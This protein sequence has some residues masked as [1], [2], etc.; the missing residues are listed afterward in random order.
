MRVT[1]CRRHP[2]GGERLVEIVERG[3][4]R[5][6][7]DSEF[8]RARRRV[9]LRARATEPRRRMGDQRLGVERPKARSP[10]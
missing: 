10:P 1:V 7:E 8:E 2:R 5:G 3:D 6:A 9:E 4:R